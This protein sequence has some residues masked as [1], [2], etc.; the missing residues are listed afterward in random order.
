MSLAYS[1]F[2]HMP[3]YLEWAPEDSLDSKEETVKGYKTTKEESDDNM[4]ID[5]NQPQNNEGAD[6]VQINKTEEKSKGNVSENLSKGNPEPGTTIFVKNVNFQTRNDAL[7]T[8]NSYGCVFNFLPY[9][10]YNFIML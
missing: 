5:Q 10:K 9:L 8:V 6:N 1:K 7:R 2:K 4:K 3:L